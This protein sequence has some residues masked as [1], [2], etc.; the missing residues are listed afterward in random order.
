ML[1]SLEPQKIRQ[2][3]V[4]EQQHQLLLLTMVWTY[5]SCSSQLKELY[6]SQTLFIFKIVVKILYFS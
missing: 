6:L 1:P 3:L 4:T 2:I 5:S